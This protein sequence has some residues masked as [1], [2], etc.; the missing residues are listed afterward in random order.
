MKIAKTLIQHGAD[1]TFRNE[2]GESVA[3]LA[4]NHIAKGISTIFYGVRE[5]VHKG[6]NMIRNPAEAIKK[7][8]LHTV[9]FNM[10][11]LPSF[12]MRFKNENDNKQSEQ[13]DFQ[14]RSGLNNNLN[15]QPTFRFD[16]SH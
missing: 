4:L 7:S 12:E 10:E 9:Q 11:H 5:I 13:N 6:L 2:K 16:F 15:S 3:G 14:S 1:L 8:N